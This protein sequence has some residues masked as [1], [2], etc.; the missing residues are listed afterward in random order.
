[1]STADRIARV[2]R[3]TRS[4]DILALC[5]EVERLQKALHKATYRKTADRAAYQREY[6]RKYRKKASAS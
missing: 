5:D 2:R 1:M 6:M 4:E 3:S